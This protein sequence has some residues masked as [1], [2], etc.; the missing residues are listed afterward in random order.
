M[1]LSKK[2]L[3]QKALSEESQSEMA[4]NTSAFDTILLFDA[5]DSKNPITTC[6]MVTKSANGARL[7]AGAPVAT[8]CTRPE[9]EYQLS[10]VT[11]ST[12]WIPIYRMGFFAVN[13]YT[14]QLPVVMVPGCRPFMR[15]FG[16][17]C[18]PWGCLELKM[19]DDRIEHIGTRENIYATWY[20]EKGWVFEKGVLEI[21]RG[22]GLQFEL[23]VVISALAVIEMRGH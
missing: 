12:P 10:A 1:P 22:G 17:M 18:R 8:M 4:R 2:P 13:D 21:R 19:T 16:W 23:G 6:C 9:A 7:T 3:S 14:F 11:T 5:L 15:S 20:Y